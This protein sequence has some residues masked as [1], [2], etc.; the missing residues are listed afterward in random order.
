M[1]G[2]QAAVSRYS[3]FFFFCLWLVLFFP[4]WYGLSYTKVRE[5]QRSIFQ[6]RD[7]QLVTLHPAGEMQQL[8]EL[9]QILDER[10]EAR[11]SAILLPIPN[12]KFPLA[13]DAT[14]LRAVFYPVPVF[15]RQELSPELQLLAIVVT[16]VAPSSATE[17]DDGQS[18]CQE[19]I[20]ETYT[21]EVLCWPI[22]PR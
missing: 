16:D 20:P 21:G 22:F 18:P 7:Q 9:K 13:S 15:A 5:L 6:T 19:Q 12:T 4:G 8:V 17:S 11:S 1:R 10:S 2:M 3:F 14:M